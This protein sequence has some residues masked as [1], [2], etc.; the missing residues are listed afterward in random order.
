[1]QWNVRP[2]ATKSCIP[3]EIY[4][5]VLMMCIVYIYLMCISNLTTFVSMWCNMSIVCYVHVPV[6]VVAIGYERVGGGEERMNNWIKC[7]LRHRTQLKE[8]EIANHYTNQ[9]LEVATRPLMTYYVHYRILMYVCIVNTIR[10]GIHTFTKT[11]PWWSSVY[12]YKWKN[13]FYKM[14]GDV[15]M[16]GHEKERKQEDA[17]T[18]IQ[19]HS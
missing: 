7:L 1:M 19:T 12:V 10:C 15:G 5:P 16:S 4:V 9:L 8:G 3:F 18:K 14:K 6:S 17:Y 13:H 2:A 11:P